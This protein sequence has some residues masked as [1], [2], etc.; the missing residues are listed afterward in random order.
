MLRVKLQPR[1]P[2]ESEM[3]EHMK[4]I[5]KLAFALALTAAILMTG[6]A[7]AEKPNY[8]GHKGT[9]P[10]VEDYYPSKKAQ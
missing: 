2:H 9:S 8:Q 6:C 3:K 1:P 4:T 7:T 5:T 10:T